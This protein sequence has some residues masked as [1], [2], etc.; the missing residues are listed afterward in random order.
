M[1]SAVKKGALDQEFQSEKKTPLV[2]I[3]RITFIS[4]ALVVFLLG[5]YSAIDIMG[6][7]GIQTIEAIVYV[8]FSIS[9]AF[10]SI[11]FSQAVLGFLIFLFSKNP[12]YTATG[13]QIEYNP[14]SI[15]T[16]TALLVPVY[17]ED[18]ER[19]AQRVRAVYRSLQ[20]ELSREKFS[21]F[22][23]SD[24]QNEESGS[25]ETRVFAKLRTELDARINFAYRRRVPNAG[26][27]AGNI[28]DFCTR[29]GH[30]YDYMIILDADSIMSG[31][32]I[33]KLIQMMEANTKAGIIQTLALLVQGET[34]FARCLQFG[35]RLCGELL[36][37][38]GSFW[39]LGQGNYYGHNAIIRVAPFTKHCKLPKY[40]DQG[41]LGG[42]I[43][44]HDFVEA[45]YLIRAGYEVWNIP[46]GSGSYEEL[47]SNIIDY[48]K[49]DRRWCQGNLQHSRVLIEKGIHPI[50]RFHFV[51][52]IMAYVSSLMWF[53]IIVLAMGR[54][55]YEALTGHVY[56]ENTYQL[57]PIWPEFKTKEAIRLFCATLGL[58]LSPKIFGAFLVILNP[59]Q[60]KQYGGILSLCLGIFVETIF[61]TLIAPVMMIFNSQFIIG[62]L[63]GKGVIWSAQPREARG[64]GFFEAFACLKWQVFFG[65]AILAV[66]TLLIPDQLWWIA[67][68]LFGSLLAL[69]MTMISSDEKF[70]HYFR[71]IRLFSVPEEL[72]P[73]AELV[74]FEESN[75]GSPR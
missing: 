59:K 24:T 33:V 34:F 26:R 75:R 25:K 13:I 9:F 38:G 70:G 31:K 5:N 61:S 15:K 10:V 42:E 67:P 39:Q 74:A 73:P 72:Y 48:A 7:N 28:M 17:N 16:K 21:V 50:S 56:F 62:I 20:T 43:L 23:L 1:D 65:I 46:S 40:K 27:K 57:F 22:I 64:I 45:A 68:I 2:F 19:V 18:P 53:L 3:R 63:S 69:P 29:W 30:E 51:Q 35:H 6:A 8:L 37:A 4:I 55:S 58:L 47:P 60:L 54:F 14:N 36:T 12:T 41:P 32:T 66:L 11:G 52:G 44:S 71:K 49:R